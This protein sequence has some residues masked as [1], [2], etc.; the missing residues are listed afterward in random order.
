VAR[1]TPAL[2]PHM[3]H[4]MLPS[5][6]ADAT[7]PISRNTAVEGLMQAG[8]AFVGLVRCQHVLDRVVG[9]DAEELCLGRKPRREKSHHRCLD[10]HAE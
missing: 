8:D 7:V 5:L 10:Q 3:P 1:G 6:A 4:G 2:V 9:P